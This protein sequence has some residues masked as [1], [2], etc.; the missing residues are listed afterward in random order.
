MSWLF[1]HHMIWHVIWKGWTFLSKLL[2][3]ITTPHCHYYQSKWSP[4]RQLSK[5]IWNKKKALQLSTFA[6]RFI[7]IFTKFWWLDSSIT[8]TMSRNVTKLQI[9]FSY[10]FFCSQKYQRNEFINEVF[11]FIIWI[12][13]SLLHFIDYVKKISSLKG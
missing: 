10:Y 12:P 13:N 2:C 11:W 9:L 4:T 3:L 5:K 6:N 8:T 1:D 7:E